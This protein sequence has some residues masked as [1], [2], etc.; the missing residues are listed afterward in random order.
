MRMGGSGARELGLAAAALAL[1]LAPAQPARAETPEAGKPAAEATDLR[2]G[3]TT[4]Q[5]QEVFQ[6][7]YAA[8]QRAEKESRERYLEAPESMP[9]VHL[10]DE[11]AEKYKR[12]IAAKHGLT[13]KQLEEIGIEG[14]SKD[15]RV[16]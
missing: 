12:E 11:L 14:F 13:R 16:R 4:A 7:I 1:W 3:L 6:E 10:E 2:F 5:R 8:L 15:W 9:R